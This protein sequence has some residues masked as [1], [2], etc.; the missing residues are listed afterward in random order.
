MNTNIFKTPTGYTIISDLGVFS[1]KED[2]SNYSVA[3]QQECIQLSID[4]S[5]DR[6]F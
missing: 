4:I 1:T 6:I 3:E 2:L 5:N